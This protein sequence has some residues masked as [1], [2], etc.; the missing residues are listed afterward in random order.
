MIRSVK[1][2]LALVLVLGMASTEA[3]AATPPPGT[4]DVTFGRNGMAVVDFPQ[5]D[6]AWKVLVQPD[7][8]IVVAG[9]VGDHIGVIRLTPT[10]Q[11]DRT[12][13]ADGRT[14]IDIGTYAV[15]IGLAVGSDGSIVVGAVVYSDRRWASNGVVNLAGNIAL[16]GVRF[17][18]IKLRPNGALDPSFGRGGIVLSQ[19]DQVRPGDDFAVDMAMT[20][21]GQI[22]VLATRGKFV[23]LGYPAA[24]VMMRFTPAGRVDESFGLA[25]IAPQGYVGALPY[26]VAMKVLRDGRLLVLWSLA[27]QDLLFPVEFIVGVGSSDQDYLVSRH[28]PSGLLDPTFG[29]AGVARADSG[30]GDYP[31]GLT[32]DKNG[33][34]L[35]YGQSVTP[36]RF[37]GT[38]MRLSPDGSVDGT[39][40]AA[41]VVTIPVGPSSNIRSITLQRD[42]RIL[43]A[44]NAYTAFGVARFDANGRLDPTFGSGGYRSVPLAVVGAVAMQS[45]RLLVVGEGKPCTPSFAAAATSVESIEDQSKGDMSIPSRSSRGSKEQAENCKPFRPVCECPGNQ[46]PRRLHRDGAHPSERDRTVPA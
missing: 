17:A 11:P 13:S 8:R 45:S 31:W 36:G 27:E 14:T 44:V 33:R 22:L 5:H 23:V 15:P 16:D 6:M 4:I 37:N 1:V 40:G 39:F 30:D 9:F 28:L 29:P 20:P 12:F 32:V 42:G 2:I 38:I 19:T 10:G 41:G 25:G 7:R 43:A 35:V 34:I 3:M 24:T 26:P 21:S 18:L 46:Q